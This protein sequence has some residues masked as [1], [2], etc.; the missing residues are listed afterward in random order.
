MIGRNIYT[1]CFPQE[2]LEPFTEEQVFAMCVDYT[3]E[4]KY[5]QQ[6]K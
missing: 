4:G 1:E 2:Y 5:F 6:S 3:M